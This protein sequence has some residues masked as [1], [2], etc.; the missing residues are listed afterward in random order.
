MISRKLQGF[1]FGLVVPEVKKAPQPLKYQNPFTLEWFLIDCTKIRDDTVY[2]L[3]KMINPDYP[4][5][6]GLVP[7]STTLIDSKAMTEHIRWVEWW[8]STNG[9]TC[10]HIVEEWERELE[11]AGI[12]KEK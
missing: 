12:V 5:L 3:L 1:F 8:L 7:A 9:H 4:K 6:N 10:R 11:K 2:N